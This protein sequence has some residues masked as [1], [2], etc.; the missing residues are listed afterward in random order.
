MPLN[1]SVTRRSPV[2]GRVQCLCRPVRARRR[3]GRN[4]QAH[5]PDGRVRGGT[6]EHIDG[7]TD[8]SQRRRGR[9]VHQRQRLGRGR[10]GVP[11]TRAGS[12][13]RWATVTTGRTSAVRC[14]ADRPVCRVHQGGRALPQRLLRPR[15]AVPAW[16]LVPTSSTCPP[17]SAGSGPSS[18][19]GAARHGD[20]RGAARCRRLL[21]AL[22]ARGATIGELHRAGADPDRLLIVEHSPT[23]RARWAYRPSTRTGAHRRDRRDRRGPTRRRSTWPTPRPTTSTGRSR[24]RRR[25]HRRRGD[26]ADRHRCH[27]LAD[28]HDA[29][30]GAWAGLRR[31]LRDVHHRAHA[32]APG[33]QGGPTPTRASSRASR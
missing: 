33:R 31:A 8:G 26:A 3:Y 12:C 7:S 9:S 29:G 27:P 24:D 4:Q 2:A 23:T 16:T 13:T 14:A 11:R 22:A 20:R 25:L 5:R 1:W 10:V 17:T 19:A 28:R 6:E 15:R 21:L 18:T 32:P 30:R